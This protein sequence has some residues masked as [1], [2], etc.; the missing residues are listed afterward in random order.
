MASSSRK[1]VE[2]PRIFKSDDPDDFWFSSLSMALHV[3]F[4]IRINVFPYEI[5]FDCV[6]SNDKPSLLR[7]YANSN[8]HPCRKAQAVILHPVTE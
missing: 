4:C 3:G 2:R 1:E 7:R 5:N 6:R 8:F